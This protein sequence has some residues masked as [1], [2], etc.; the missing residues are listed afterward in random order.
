MHR[1]RA[2]ALLLLLLEGEP[3]GPALMQKHQML[4][5][6]RRELFHFPAFERGDRIASPPLPHSSATSID[7][8]RSSRSMRGGMRWETFGRDW[9]R[10]EERKKEGREGG[11]EGRS[12]RCNE[13]CV[14]AIKD[15]EVEGKEWLVGWCGVA[16]FEFNKIDGW[17]SILI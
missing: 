3:T 2:S 12:K 5:R 11:R 8:G 1:A 10:G 4:E 17:F 15:E 13:R 9:R 14:S 7:S 16:R 6:Q